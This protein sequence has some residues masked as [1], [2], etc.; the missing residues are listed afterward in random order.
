MKEF[1]LV[2]IGGEP[3]NPEDLPKHYTE[4]GKFMSY[5]NNGNHFKSGIPVESSVGRMVEN[6][7]VI[8]SGD[9]MSI[10]NKIGGIM[11]IKADD[12]DHAADLARHNPIIRNGGRILVWPVKN[13]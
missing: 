5:L 9:F 1:V 12:I 3:E 11:V 4:Y 13:I 10:S 2:F 7:A 8:K 6:D